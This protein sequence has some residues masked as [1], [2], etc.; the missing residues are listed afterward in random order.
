MRL[1]TDCFSVESVAAM[2]MPLI[3]DAFAPFIFTVE[4][5]AVGSNRSGCFRLLG[6]RC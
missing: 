2:I 3:I 6:T 1:V 5:V 4:T